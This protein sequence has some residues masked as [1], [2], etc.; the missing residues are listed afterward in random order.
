MPTVLEAMGQF[1][2]VWIGLVI[3]LLIFYLFKFLF[4]FGGENEEQRKKRKEEWAEDI[5]KIRAA[6]KKNEEAQKEA[7]KQAREQQDRERKARKDALINATTS[8]KKKEVERKEEVVQKE[9]KKRENARPKVNKF[10]DYLIEA[11]AALNEAIKAL[12]DE[13]EA[14]KW[15]AKSKRSLTKV[16]DLGVLEELTKGTPYEEFAR[17]IHA[18][19]VEVWKNIDQHGLAK[20]TLQE[21]NRH[22]GAAF[23]GIGTLI[24]EFYGADAARN[25]TGTRGARPVAVFRK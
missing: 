20:E 12:P 5:G 17:L 23:K 13:K 11:V 22:L 10:A 16:H 2:D 7:E 14:K 4:M 18:N 1:L 8:Q 3:A 15:V 19:V 6:M 9:Q 24:E 21:F 25:V